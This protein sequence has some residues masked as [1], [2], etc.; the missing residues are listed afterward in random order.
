MKTRSNKIM[1]LIKRQ[2]KTV[3][4]FIVVV[5]QGF[6]ARKGAASQKGLDL[7]FSLINSLH[8]VIAVASF[9]FLVNRGNTGS[10][11]SL[12]FARVEVHD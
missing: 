2:R 11:G 8:F 6:Y 5:Q 9:S 4:I 3:L 10:S 7:C 1:T 12:P